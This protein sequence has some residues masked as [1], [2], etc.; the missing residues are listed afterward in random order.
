MI[1]KLVSTGSNKT[2]T[3]RAEELCEAIKAAIY[4]NAEGMSLAAVI[5]CIEVAK[6]EIME[7]QRE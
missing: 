1:I 5:G 4:D 6:L 3:D 7:D 2:H